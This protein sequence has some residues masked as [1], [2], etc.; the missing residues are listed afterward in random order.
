MKL[1]IKNMVCPCCV[2][3]VNNM[4]TQ[5]GLIGAEVAPGS[6]T[7]SNRPS[8]DKLMQLDAMLREM[9]MEIVH[10]KRNMIVEKM[11]SMIR[12]L[13]NSD[14]DPL[15]INLSVFLSEQLHYNYSYLSNL[16]SEAEGQTIRDY[17]I[18]LRIERVKQMLVVEQ[19]DLLEISCRLN[20]S[21]V[22]HLA[23]QFKKVTGLT[24]SEYKKKREN[25]IFLARMTG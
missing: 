22:S 14:H 9:E 18:T 13:V 6:V 7:L 15:K 3:Y 1:V 21:S 10:E 19:L 12:E 23:A 5:L 17:G 25:G 8:D 24:T 20:Y 16:F 2:L 11:K 4:L